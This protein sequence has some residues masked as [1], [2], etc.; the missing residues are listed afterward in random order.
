MKQR[1][2][3][4]KIENLL[5]VTR[6]ITVHYFEFDEGYRS[7]GESHDFWEMVYADRG[8]LVC[9][10]EGEE[11]VL[12]EGEAIFHKPNEFHIH[13]ADGESAPSVFIISFEC[14]SEAIHV[15]EYK[16][17]RLE[18]ELSAYVYMILEEARR[19]F[20]L[21]DAGPDVKRM[22][23]AK[24]PALGGMQYIKNLLELL[25]IGAIRRIDGEEEATSFIHRENFGEYLVEGVIDYLTENISGRVSIDEICHRMNYTRSYLFRQFKAVTGQSI[26]AYFASLKVKEAKRLLRQTDMSVTEI[27]EALSFDTPNYF[28]KTFKRISGYTPLEYRRRRRGW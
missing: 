3:K 16:R 9:T 26:M 5:H 22:P 17:M 14:K 18:R 4:H 8:R 24:S 20:E 15:L 6:I 28:S 12:D 19:T 7:P 2:Y 27:A 11:L 21:E 23:L 1:Y 10:V 13:A 25:L